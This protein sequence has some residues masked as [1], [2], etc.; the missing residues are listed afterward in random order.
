MDLPIVHRLHSRRQRNKG[1]L[2]SYVEA[3]IEGVDG[4]EA[5]MEYKTLVLV[6]KVEHPKKERKGREEEVKHQK[7]NT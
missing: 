7:E 4:Y 6:Y 3:T 1:T 2:W 5:R